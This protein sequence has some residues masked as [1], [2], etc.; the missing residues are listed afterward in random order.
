MDDTTSPYQRY[1]DLTPA[2]ESALRASIERFGVLVPVV[3]DQHGN[4][5][6]GHQRVRIADELGVKYPVNIIEV[7]DEAEALETLRLFAEMASLAEA[8]DQ[9]RAPQADDEDSR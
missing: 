4:V 1:K 7:A 6:D 9:E 2:I 5:L 8:E 3:R